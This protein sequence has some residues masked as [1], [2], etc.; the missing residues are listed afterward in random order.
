MSLL[1]FFLKK[2]GLY[3]TAINNIYEHR[4][5]TDPLYKMCDAYN[6]L[7]RNFS[8]SSLFRWSKTKQG[9]SF[10]FDKSN[11]F[12]KLIEKFKLYHTNNSTDIET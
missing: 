4:H 10:W 7:N 9:Y 5:K 1:E 6:A 11:E 3:K 8:I 12:N 2:N